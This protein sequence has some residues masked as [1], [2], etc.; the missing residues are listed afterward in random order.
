MMSIQQLW[1]ASIQGV[2]VFGV[3]W[4]NSGWVSAADPPK[5]G[6]ILFKTEPPKVNIWLGDRQ[7][8]DETPLVTPALAPGRYKFRFEAQDH[9]SQMLELEVQA[10]VLATKALTMV[11][12]RYTKMSKAGELLP[13]TATEWACVYDKTT[14][15]LWEVQISDKKYTW[16]DALNK[17]PGEINPAGLCGQRDWRLP[18]K[19][20][21]LSLITKVAPP[22]IDSDYFPS[23]PASCFWSSS[24]YADY[25]SNAWFVSFGSGD[26]CYYHKSY[27]EFVRLVRGGQ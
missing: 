7:L 1:R 25:S 16:N 18:N 22:T 21:L 26:G 24:P 3:L 17:R 15:L 8:G 4:G 6:R 19:E 5:P 11:A 23:T 9:E 27:S 20:E 14:K 2:I 12:F 10:D 13:V